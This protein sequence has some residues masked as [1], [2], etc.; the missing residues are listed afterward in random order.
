M[1]E[2]S[3]FKQ[4]DIFHLED[5]M[6]DVIERPTETLIPEQNMDKKVFLFP[7]KSVN[8]KKN[9]VTGKKF[10]K[11]T[12]ENFEKLD[13]E[14]IEIEEDEKLLYSENY[15]GE[16]VE[17]EKGF[18]ISLQDKKGNFSWFLMK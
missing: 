13:P 17:T 5:S 6:F 7:K 10:K 12:F 18:F 9:I 11:G 2:S 14:E 1:T 15:P 3:D 4:E 8:K 16:I